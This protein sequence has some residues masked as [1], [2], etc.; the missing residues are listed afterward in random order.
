MVA[1]TFQPAKCGPTARSGSVRSVHAQT[2]ALPPILVRFG[3][4]SDRMGVLSCEKPARPRERLDSIGPFGVQERHHRTGSVWILDSDA[5]R[6]SYDEEITGIPCAR[7]GGVS[8]GRCSP[9]S[10]DGGG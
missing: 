4:P 7:S 1:E 8:L 3:R 6:R 2:R 10:A 9:P 5:R